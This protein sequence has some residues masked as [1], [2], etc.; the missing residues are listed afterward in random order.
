MTLRRPRRRG[1]SPQRTLIN[2]GSVGVV[3]AGLVEL[4]E[5]GR[6]MFGGATSPQ[7][8]PEA[9]IA[10]DGNEPAHDFEESFPLVKGRQDQEDAAHRFGIDGIE[11]Y[12]GLEKARHPNDLLDK[13]GPAMGKGDS[14][15]EGGR[16]QR[17]PLLE[18]A[19]QASFRRPGDL[20]QRNG[21]AD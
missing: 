6:D 5:E 2:P 16:P 7:K 18:R 20:S 15:S 17:F 19:N 10:T 13:T 12:P 4:L 3:E 9:P 21:M 14:F 1:R 11:G 8:N